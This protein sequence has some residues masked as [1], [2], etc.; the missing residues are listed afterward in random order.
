MKLTLIKDRLY[1]LYLNNKQG[2]QVLKSKK[3]ERSWQFL[4]VNIIL[5]LI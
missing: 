4:S 5:S 2:D 1:H 3:T